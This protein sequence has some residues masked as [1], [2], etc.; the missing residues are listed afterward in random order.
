MPISSYK[1]LRFLADLT[2]AN[3]EDD[4][5]LWDVVSAFRLLAVVLHDPKRHTQ[6]HHRLSSRFERLDRVTGQRLLFFA[7]V[8]VDDQWRRKAERRHYFST[9]EQRLNIS[10]ARATP[11]HSVDPELSA[12][13]S[14]LELGI[15]ANDLP[16][17]V[18]FEGGARE[19][20]WI[21]TCAS[22]IE[23]QLETLALAAHDMDSRETGRFESIDDYLADYDLGARASAVDETGSV[24]QSLASVLA[25]STD[26]L[27]LCRDSIRSKWEM[28]QE[29]LSSAQLDSSETLNE[30]ARSALT[31]GMMIALSHGG[32][33]QEEWPWPPRDLWELE[34]AASL[35][36][37]MRLRTLDD[38]ESVAP[39]VICYGRA[40][41]AEI[42]LSIVQALR[43][44]LGVQMPEYFG[45]CQSGVSAI[46][47]VEI[48]GRQRRV[49]LNA[50]RAGRWMPPGLGQSEMVARALGVGDLFT[51]A[52]WQL[53]LQRWA[54]I[55]RHRNSAAHP[56][57]VEPSSVDACHQALHDLNQNE[58]LGVVLGI[59]AIM[60]GTTPE[61]DSSGRTRSKSSD[62][63]SS[64][65]ESGTLPYRVLE[66]RHDGDFIV[67]VHHLKQAAVRGPAG[68]MDRT[69]SADRLRRL[70]T[71]AGLRTDR[72]RSETIETAANAP[73]PAIRAAVAACEFAVCLSSLS[74]RDLAREYELNMLRLN[75]LLGVSG[76]GL[77]LDDNH[78]K[79]CNRDCDGLVQ[80]LLGALSD[81]ASTA[82]PEQKQ[83]GPCRLQPSK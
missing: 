22:S 42:N 26:H 3:C 38:M 30:V 34:A 13:S 63:R 45:R 31:L 77:G 9:I 25:P 59:K 51:P 61:E 74:D 14:A 15:P 60:R 41:E 57:L 79:R 69:E 65:S 68:D 29:A 12:V 17:V 19:F 76:I 48:G 62:K 55:R 70:L 5:K 44:Q 10:Y 81:V 49:N 2:S 58:V 78:L 23:P 11:T 67:A 72:S 56:G 35:A 36:T 54:I 1:V 28:F 40:F 32:T 4:R 64:A 18:V 43:Q 6:L 20:C 66:L 50:K 46:A 73:V 16:C 82:P 80:C 24:A 21:Q 27:D 7:L 33:V 8:E 47:D 37:A 75:V 39:I 71:V 53:L 52:N 83:E